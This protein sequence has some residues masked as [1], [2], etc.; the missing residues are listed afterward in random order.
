MCIWR[1][2][3]TKDLW[4][5]EEFEMLSSL[6]PVNYW[7]KAQAGMFTRLTHEDH[8]DV[9]SYLGERG[10]LDLLEKFVIPGNE[11]MKALGDLEA[12]NIGYATLFPD[13]RG[14]A[15]QA[16]VGATWKIFGSLS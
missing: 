7:Q 5:D 16:N 12:M 9:C 1:L 3:I 4:V 10:L 2:G 15:L 14:A 6:S 8:V 11:T 13:L